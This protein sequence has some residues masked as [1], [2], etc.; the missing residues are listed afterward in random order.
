MAHFPRHDLCHGVPFHDTAP[1]SRFPSPRERLP[2][3][4]WFITKQAPVKVTKQK[5]QRP[6]VGTAG[7][8]VTIRDFQSPPLPAIPRSFRL[9]TQHHPIEELLKTTN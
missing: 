6:M 7:C 3:S 8:P 2:V 5:S 9:S 4:L 1:S